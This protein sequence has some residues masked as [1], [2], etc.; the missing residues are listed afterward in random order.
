MRAIATHQRYGFCGNPANS[1]SSLLL[2]RCCVAACRSFCSRWSSLSPT[3][4][5]AVPRRT[6]LALLRRSCNALLIG[7]HCLVETTLRYPY[8]RQ[9]DSAP[10]GVR[11]VP[12]PLHPCHALGIRPV[13]CLQIPARPGGESQE[14]RCRSAPEMVV[15]RC[16]VERPPGV[17]HGAGHIAQSQGHGRHGTRRSKPGRRRN[18]SSSTTT[19]SAAGAPASRQSCL[20]SYPATVRRP[21]AGPPRPRARRQPVTPRHTQR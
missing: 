14:P 17:C 20:P 19:I 18:S 13:R 10:E 15:L 11:E 5:S 9:G 12:G 8:I 6:R 1:P 2:S 7:A 3:Y 16:E 21:A 4:M